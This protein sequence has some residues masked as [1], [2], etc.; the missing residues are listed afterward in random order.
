[1]ALSSTRVMATC[2]LMGQAVGTAC[3]VAKKYAVSP[4][5]VLGHIEELQQMLRDD[6]C[7][8]LHTPRRVS[9]TMKNAETNLTSKEKERSVLD[10]HR[11]FS[12]ERQHTLSHEK[13]FPILG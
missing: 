2:A 10:K 13:Q 8:L 11:P 6:D 3:A 1:M 9:V 4:R 7:Y 12:Y 5:G